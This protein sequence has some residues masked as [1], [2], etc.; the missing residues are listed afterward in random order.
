MDGERVVTNRHPDFMVTLRPQ[1]GRSPAQSV[2]TD[3]AGQFQFDWV[4]PGAYTL[5]LY[6]GASFQDEQREVNVRSGEKCLTLPKF[7]LRSR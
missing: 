5:V 1:S 7:V 2:A 4:S 6:G 3:G